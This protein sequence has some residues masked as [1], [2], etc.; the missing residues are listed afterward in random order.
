MN[1]SII[2]VDFFKTEI[3]PEYFSFPPDFVNLISL[4]KPPNLFPWWLM[5]H[6][7]G[8][9]D[10]WLKLLRR[11]YPARQLIPFAKYDYTDDIACFD[12]S[13]PSKNPSVYYIH[14]FAT[15][16]WENRGNVIDFN[17]WLQAALEDARRDKEGVQ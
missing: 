14:M 10:A 12:A 8:T 3:L 1:N 15:P 5:C 6:Y 11:S 16:G 7:P 17:A 2:G 4:K 9:S 13:L